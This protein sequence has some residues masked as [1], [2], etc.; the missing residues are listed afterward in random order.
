MVGLHK[1][2]DEVRLSDGSDIPSG[3]HSDDLKLVSLFK[4]K[5]D[6]VDHVDLFFLNIDQPDLL[7]GEGEESAEESSHGAGTHDDCFHRIPLS[8]RC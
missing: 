4:G 7:P 5:A 1:K 6:G 3:V 2:D 8:V